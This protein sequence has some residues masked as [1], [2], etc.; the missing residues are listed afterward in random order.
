[1]ELIPFVV[2]FFMS[3]LCYARDCVWLIVVTSISKP[4]MSEKTYENIACFSFGV[5]FHVHIKKTKLKIISQKIKK[6]KN[7]RD[8]Q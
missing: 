5:Q 3:L 6:R 7:K 1:M 2:V 8:I 4:P